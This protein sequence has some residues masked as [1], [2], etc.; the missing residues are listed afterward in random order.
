MPDQDPQAYLQLIEKLLNCPSGEEPALL[1]ANTDLLDGPF[2]Q[3]LDTVAQQLAKQSPE[4]AHFLRR[5]ATH[6]SNANSDRAPQLHLRRLFSTLQQTEGDPQAVY[7]LLQQQDLTAAHQPALATL[8]QDMLAQ[9]PP[10]EHP[11]LAALFG[12]LGNLIQQYPLGNRAL[13]QELGITAYQLTLQVFTRDAFPQYW[14]TTQNNLGTAYRER[15]EGN[16][17][18]NLERAIGHYENALQVYTPETSPQHW[19]STQDNLALAYSDRIV[20]S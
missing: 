6:L 2:L 16:P 17:A 8:W 14:A 11:G 5:L 19:A 3:H 10:A 15:I 20:G 4:A 1:Q 18:E 7:A 9:L 13:N 12:K